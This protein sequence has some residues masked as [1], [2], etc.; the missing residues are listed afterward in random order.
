MRSRSPCVRFP[1]TWYSNAS[2]RKIVGG[3]SM[4]DDL[5]YVASATAMENLSHTR[6]RLEKPSWYTIRG[7]SARRRDIPTE[8]RFNL[9]SPGSGNV[10]FRLDDDLTR[11]WINSRGRMLN[12]SRNHHMQPFEVHTDG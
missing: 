11:H 7:L 2:S 6:G 10:Q 4:A 9:P 3:L 5:R 12:H 1:R 8:P